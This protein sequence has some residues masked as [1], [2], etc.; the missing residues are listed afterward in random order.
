MTQAE[1]AN[2]ADRMRRHIR[3]LQQMQKR[4]LSEDDLR[5]ALAISE[6]YKADVAYVQSCV[7]ALNLIRRVKEHA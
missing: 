5:A 7:D 6:S 1:F 4:T 3:I 2:T